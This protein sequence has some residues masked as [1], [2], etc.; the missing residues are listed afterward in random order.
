MKYLFVTFVI[1]G[2]KLIAQGVIGHIKYLHESE[3]LRIP[4]LFHDLQGIICII[5]HLP[6]RH[7]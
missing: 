2:K 7:L 4:L 6:N 3:L 5:G 1:S